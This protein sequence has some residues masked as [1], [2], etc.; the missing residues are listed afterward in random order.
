VEWYDSG[1]GF[2]IPLEDIN[3][4]FPRLKEGKNLERGLLGITWPQETDMYNAPPAITTV[5]PKSAAEAAGIK[6]G[7]VITEMDGVKVS[8]ISQVMHVLGT[9]Y[10]GDTISVKVKRGA[11]EKRFANL[12]LTGVL[13]AQAQPFL[14]ILP[15][16]DDPEPGVEVR[17]VFPDSPA[18]AAGIKAGDRVLSMGPG[19]TPTPFSGRDDFM[20]L[21]ARALPGSEMKVEVRRPGAKDLLT[22]TLRLGAISETIPDQLPQPATLKKAL[23]PR[24]MAKPK[25]PMPPMPPEGPKKEEKKDPKKKPETG[26]LSRSNA[27]GDRN[28]WIWVPE[29]YDPNIAYALIVWLHPPGEGKEKDVKVMAAKWEADCEDHHMIIVAPKAE[30]EIG[31]LASE[32]DA[33]RDAINAVAA[34]YTIDRQRIVAHGMDSGGQMAFRMGFAARDLIRGVATTGAVL[35]LQP[36]ADPSNQRLSFF[37]ITGD[38]DPLAKLIIESKDKLAGKKY[39]VVFRQIAN[40]GHQYPDGTVVSELVRWIDS[41]DRQ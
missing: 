6:A 15:M 26:F 40:M 41:L 2:A 14:G 31:W 3:A 39:P 11:E 37:V 22:L 17:Y 4:V 33:V 10:E 38:K 27:A 32:S 9:K 36:G 35:P 16:R 7:D 1:I 20:E 13:T 30:N 28:Y 24:K 12:K 23:E 25:P 21:L 29:N 8:R 19:K 5:I 34:E 18:S